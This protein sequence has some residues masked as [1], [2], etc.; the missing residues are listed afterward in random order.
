MFVH[1]GVL[2]NRCSFSASNRRKTGPPNRCNAAK[3]VALANVLAERQVERWGLGRLGGEHGERGASIDVVDPLGIC[4][5][6]TGFYGILWD[7]MG[8][9]GIFWDFIG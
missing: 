7:F 3:A 2:F 1:R 9:H 8:F 5:I 6:T 4:Y